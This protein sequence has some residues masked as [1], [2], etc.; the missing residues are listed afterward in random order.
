MMFPAFDVKGTDTA[1]QAF[2]KVRPGNSADGVK[3]VYE[4]KQLDLNKTLDEQ[5]VKVDTTV[6]IK[7]GDVEPQMYH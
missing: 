6:H 7:Y 3:L 2:H 1:L 4:G 5:G